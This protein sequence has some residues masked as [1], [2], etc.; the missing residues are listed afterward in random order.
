M[1]GRL[2]RWLAPVP[3]LAALVVP[4]AAPAAPSSDGHGWLGEELPLPLAVRTAQDLAVKAAA[5][6][7]YLI[8]NL[9]AGG[10]LAW[11][12]GDF[13][14]AAGKWEALLRLQSLDP[15][16][17]KVIRPLAREARARAGGVA[18]TAPPVATT[19]SDAVPTPPVGTGTEPRS[20]TAPTVVSG[21]VKGGG[22]H[23]PGG[24]VIWLKRASGETPRPA[25]AHGKVV[26]QRSKTF[27]PHVLAVPVGTKVSFRNEDPLFHN[28]FS[29]SKPNDF[30][31]GLY[32]QGASYEKTFK[33][34]GVVQVLCNIHSSMLGVIVVVDTPYYAQADGSGAFTIKGVP[35]GD[36]QLTVWHEAASKPIEQRISVGPGGTR[37][38]ALQV[39]GDKR[40]PQFVPDKSGKPRQSHIGY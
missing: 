4:A 29:L 38:L 6:K 9:L 30:D 22:S 17:D 11:D 40:P 19:A 25:P 20:P 10:K 7:Q 15:E 37:G 23:G 26:T 39:G 36:Y 16:I 24:A 14:T 33:R 31:T 28:V 1:H 8:F 13:A 18:N 12:Q 21:T 32:K 35:P 3:L 34:A 5:E 2:S 27:I